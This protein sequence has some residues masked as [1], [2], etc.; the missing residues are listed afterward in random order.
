[1]KRIIKYIIERILE[2]I[3]LNELLNISFKRLISKYIIDLCST[4]MSS[5]RSC[6]PLC[7][8]IGAGGGGDTALAQFCADTENNKG[9]SYNIAMG[10]GNSWRCYKKYIS[11][12]FFGRKEFSC[13]KEG[14]QIE[15]VL[16]NLT[17]KG[18]CREGFTDED[19][20]KYLSNILVPTDPDVLKEDNVIFQ[21]SSGSYFQNKTAGLILDGDLN[22]GSY[23]SLSD[24][25]SMSS[26]LPVETYML[27]CP[28]GTGSKYVTLNGSIMTTYNL[29]SEIHYTIS[30]L[31]KFVI[32]KQ[33]KIIKLYDVGGDIF[34]KIMTDPIDTWGRD[35][36]VLLSV[37]VIRD[38]LNTKYK[39]HLDLDV[40][41]FGVGCDAHSYPDQ[42]LSKFVKYAK[43]DNEIGI[44]LVKN[45]KT[46]IKLWTEK[47]HL[48]VF[49]SLFKDDR[50]T[51]IFYN[52]VIC[53]EIKDK[54]KDKTEYYELLTKIQTGLCKRREKG[55]HDFPPFKPDKISVIIEN[56][57]K[58]GST[59]IISPKL[60]T[61][62]L[63]ETFRD[64]YKK[65]RNSPTGDLS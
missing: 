22:K 38:I 52:S 44:G 9:K 62:V 36:I 11:K 57:E 28:G 12:E 5:P 64:G 29:I 65:V 40:V 25:M 58:M 26:I 61:F 46:Y 21:L 50:A 32:D 34:N 41:V 43:C 15:A 31:L 14:I 42:V 37:I 33:V 23:N 48:Y 17:Y 10:T 45:L 55:T 13:D 56:L 18:S 30:G 24:E 19:T 2:Y 20:D 6:Q 8:H 47:P 54:D 27:Y 51:K 35:E 7:L 16:K 39:Y 4:P 63:N 53:L 59:Y 1:M 3:S 60:S 49:S